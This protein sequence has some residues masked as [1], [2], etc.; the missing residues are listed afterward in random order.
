MDN[1]TNVQLITFL[2]FVGLMLILTILMYNISQYETISRKIDS[3]EN[4]VVKLAIER[5]CQ[6]SEHRYR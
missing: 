6:Q 4:K 2:V 1:Q 3:I 5:E